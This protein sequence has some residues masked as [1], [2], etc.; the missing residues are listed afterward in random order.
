[1]S[2]CVWRGG[3]GGGGSIIDIRVAFYN[4]INACLYLSLKPVLPLLT[5]QYRTRFCLLIIMI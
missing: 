5:R 4:K 2:V 3:E 1:M